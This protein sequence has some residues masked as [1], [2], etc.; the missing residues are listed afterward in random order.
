MKISWFAP[1]YRWVEYIAFGRALEA[2]RFALI[3]RVT[4]ADRVLVIGEGDGRMIERMLTIAPEARFD[5]V[6]ISAEMIT[7]AK[8]RIGS[9][10][11]VHFHNG[12]A[13]TSSLL[14]PT[15][16]R[17]DVI[18]TLFVLDCFDEAELGP[19]IRRLAAA[20][21]PDGTWLVS[22]FAIPESGWRRLHARFLLWTMY[23]FFG[24]VSGLRVRRL[25]PIGQSMTDAG[26]YLVDEQTHRLGSIR[27]S[28]YTHGN[29]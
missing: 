3:N 15:S 20:L 16:D 19:L 28:A 27:S 26:M 7:L 23:R 18:V 10:D 2:A 12:D 24:L 1:F 13:R 29:A 6:E 5:I 8:H 17:F 4:G 9:R 22:D 14:A 11:N 25:P 21:T